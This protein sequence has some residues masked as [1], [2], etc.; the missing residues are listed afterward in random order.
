MTS[1]M[2]DEGWEEIVRAVRD[3]VRI[4]DKQSPA[5]DV[6]QEVAIEVPHEATHVAL[7]LLM[8][9]YREIETLKLK[10]ARLEAIDDA[11]PVH[12]ILHTITEF[13]A[14]VKAR[15]LPREVP[16]A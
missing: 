2:T 11:M 15:S 9:A 10:V 3:G 4:R 6:G 12:A 8:I 16:K 1:A 5:D 14:I 7:G 13:D